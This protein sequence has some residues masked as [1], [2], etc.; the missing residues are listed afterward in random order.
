MACATP[1]RPGL[2]VGDAPDFFAPLSFGDYPDSLT[3]PAHRTITAVAH[4]CERIHTNVDQMAYPIPGRIRDTEVGESP[5][6]A[7]DFDA[8]DSAS[9]RM[10]MTSITSLLDEHPNPLVIRVIAPSPPSRT[11][12]PSAVLRARFGIVLYHS[13]DR[14]G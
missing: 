2:A 8:F 6:T 12:Q 14:S 4:A 1:S 13:R 5:W 11:V 10:R 3:I 9:V 7:G